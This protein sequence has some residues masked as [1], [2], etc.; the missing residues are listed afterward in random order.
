MTLQ[1]TEQITGL[2]RT[3]I[4]R[5]ERLGFIHTKPERTDGRT[6]TE[7]QVKILLRVRLLRQLMVPEVEIRKVQKGYYN[8]K[9]VLQCCLE[10]FAESPDL[11]HA[12]DLKHTCE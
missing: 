6:Y 11:K 7:E 9:D 1:E 12:R 4:R 8:L 3:S 2:R 10:V 5:Y